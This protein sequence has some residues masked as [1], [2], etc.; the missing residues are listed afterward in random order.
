MQATNL[1]LE[2]EG[3]KTV[4]SCHWQPTGV[5][6]VLQPPD[7]IPSCLAYTCAQDCAA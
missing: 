7:N 5:Q 3:G 2:A 4:A 1:S 6:V